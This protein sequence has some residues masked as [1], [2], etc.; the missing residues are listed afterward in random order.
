[1]QMQLMREMKKS[2]AAFILRFLNTRPKTDGS[3]FGDITIQQS[4]SLSNSSRTLFS[5]SKINE[6]IVLR[7]AMNLRRFRLEIK[8]LML[9][10]KRGRERTISRDLEIL[11][12]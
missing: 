2:Q 4:T 8:R 6:R 7:F 3:L 9:A 12:D 1:M 11:R 5:I 10:P